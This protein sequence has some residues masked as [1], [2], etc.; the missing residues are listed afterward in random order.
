MIMFTEM[1]VTAVTNFGLRT[2]IPETNERKSIC[3]GLKVK[4]EKDIHPVHEH[5]VDRL[6]GQ[7]ALKHKHNIKIFV[8]AILSIKQRMTVAK[9]C[10]Q[11]SKT[12]RAG[13]S[14]T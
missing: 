7:V 14:E 12:E 8:T 6:E 10:Q 3:D 2:V 5:T 4:G 9:V 13:S 1:W 11:H